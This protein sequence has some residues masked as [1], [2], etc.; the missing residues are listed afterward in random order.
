VNDG[1]LDVDLVNLLGGV[2]VLDTLSLSLDDRLDLLNDVL[3]DVLSDDGSIDGGRVS[4]VSDRLLVGMLALRTVL[5]A[6]LFRDVFVDVARDVR[7]NVL[8]MSVE[9]LLIEDW[10]NLLVDLGLVSLSV[11][12]RCDFVVSMLEDILVYH[13]IEY[14]SCVSTTNLVIYNVF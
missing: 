14:V 10:L 3:V 11:H 5:C 1:R 9:L 8:V 2:V 13:R 12:N 4:L 6:V 7:S